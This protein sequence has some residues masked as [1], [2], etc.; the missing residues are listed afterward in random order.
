LLEASGTPEPP[1]G[2]GKGLSVCFNLSEP[3]QV[4]VAYDVS[5][6]KNICFDIGANVGFYSLLFSATRKPFMLLN[7]CLEM[8]SG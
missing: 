3:E 6:G 8:W 2:D 4:Q 7:R 1:L 5:K